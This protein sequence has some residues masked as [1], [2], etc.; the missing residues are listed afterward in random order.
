[1]ALILFRCWESW[2]AQSMAMAE[3]K[4]CFVGEVVAMFAQRVFAPHYGAKKIARL[5]PFGS[6]ASHE[7]T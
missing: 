3:T 4:M 5:D 1:M 6:I 7:V 2:D